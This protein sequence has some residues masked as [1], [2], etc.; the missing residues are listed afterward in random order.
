M[1]DRGT[2]G[3]L[4]TLA[5]QNLTA[6]SGGG[7]GWVLHTTMSSPA[8]QGKKKPAHCA[9]VCAPS[10]HPTV[11]TLTNEHQRAESQQTALQCTFS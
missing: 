3:F 4:R 1:F 9:G 11:N 7:G 10:P 8:P 5:L 2:G 6:E